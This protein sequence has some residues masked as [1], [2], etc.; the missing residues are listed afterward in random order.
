MVE[1][2]RVIGAAHS[3]KQL[4]AAVRA[5]ETKAKLKGLLIEKVEVSSGIDLRRAIADARARL[6][7]PPPRDLVD[8]TP[9]PVAIEAAPINIFEE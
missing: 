7:L 1:L 6:G 5:V 9:A 4:M 8:V 2:D 3:Q